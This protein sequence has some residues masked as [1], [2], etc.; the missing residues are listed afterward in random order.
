MYTG[1]C[2]IEKVDSCM[3]PGYVFKQHSGISDR[4]LNIIRMACNC[5]SQANCTGQ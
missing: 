3:I 1:M 4:Q 5:V 2:E